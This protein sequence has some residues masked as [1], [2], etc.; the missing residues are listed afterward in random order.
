M[1]FEKIKSKIDSFN[2][3]GKTKEAAKWL[4]KKFNLQDNYLK[5]FEFRENPDP[6]LIVLTTE[7]EFGK[8]QIIRLPDNIFQFPLAL[9][10]CMLTHEMVHVQQK[11]RIPY[12]MDK[13]EREWQAYYEMLFHKIYPNYIEISNFHKKSFATKSLEYY[14]RMGEGSQLQIKY[15]SQ[16]KEVEELIL[17]L[18]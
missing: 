17:S 2:N 12:V 6:K 9:I 11:T 15:A 3:Q 14:N 10:L 8:K 18:P 7:G 1:D 16:K 13:N 5:G 4:L